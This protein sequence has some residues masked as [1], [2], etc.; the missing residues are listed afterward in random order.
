MS[1]GGLA[2][3]ARGGCAGGVS[4]RAHLRPTLVLAGPIV[5]GQVGQTLMGLADSVM[6]G[7]VGVVPL[8]ASAFAG[9]L[10]HAVMVPGLGVLSPVSVLAARA[11]G[12]G[13]PADAGEHVRHGLWL[14]TVLGVVLAAGMLALR[15]FLGGFGQPEDVVAE[16]GPYLFWIALSIIPILQFHAL[17]QYYDAAHAPSVAMWT[18]LGGVALNILLNWLLIYGKLGFP[19]MG[20]EGAGLATLLARGAIVV[21]LWIH[22]NASRR[23][24]A[25]VPRSWWA[26]PERARVAAVLRLGLP[27][28]LQYTFEVGAFTVAALF[29]G[30]LGAVPL[31]AHQIAVQCAG[32]TFMV[33]LGISFAAS[34][35]VGRAA[36]AGHRGEL[37]SIA[38]AALV[39]SGA[40]MALFACVFLVGG[41]WIARAFVDDAEV[42]AAAAAL[43]VVAGLFQLVDGTQ[44]TALGCLRG[45]EDVRVPTVITFL[46]Y[47]VVALPLAWILAFPLGLG[48]VGV[49]AGLAVGLS[50]AAVLLTHRTW[51]RTAA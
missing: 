15:P 38:L 41:G 5:A 20:L 24:A 37:R 46:A 29:M 16:A 47:W 35:R 7:R 44:V 14:G 39:L 27:A 13:S 9:A 51:V 34:V 49:W 1:G 43:F 11:L 33:P 31:A 48:G 4:L 18:M 26:R 21:V 42:V 8:A 19:E 36:G 17:K 40:L 50:T 30:M 2:W 25:A 32:M 12:A 28:G 45:L 6:I 22:L 3:G 23:H 10:F